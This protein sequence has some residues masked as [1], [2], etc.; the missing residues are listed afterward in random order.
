[1]FCVPAFQGAS[2]LFIDFLHIFHYYLDKPQNKGQLFFIF[3]LPGSCRILVFDAGLAS[4][5][6][7][8]GRILK[9]DGQID[10]LILK[11]ISAKEVEMLN[12]NDNT[13][14]ILKLN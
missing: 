12:V 4:M 6:V 14:V 9:V 2:G 5:A 3:I 7:V 13:T 8:N 1:L 10:H 11:K